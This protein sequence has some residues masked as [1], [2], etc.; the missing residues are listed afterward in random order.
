[1]YDGN[2]GMFI[3][4]KPSQEGG[5]H[6]HPGNISAGS[7]PGSYWSRNGISG[8]FTELLI[9]A[10]NCEAVIIDGYSQKTLAEDKYAP[11]DER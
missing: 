1:M 3:K 5:K 8:F 7:A 6:P 11:G 4:L 10:E 9:N 2:N